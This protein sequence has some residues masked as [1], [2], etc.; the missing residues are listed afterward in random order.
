[1]TKITYPAP[2]VSSLRPV[3]SRQAG[4]GSEYPKN[5]AVRHTPPVP[6][7]RMPLRPRRATPASAPGRPLLSLDQFLQ[8]YNDLPAHTAALGYCDDGLPVLF[9][10]TQAATGPLLI[11]GDHGSGK[12]NLLRLLLTSAIRAST[13]R[14]LK[15][16]L[17]GAH[18]EEYSDLPAQTGDPKHCI[19]LLGSYDQE[20]G[21]AIVRMAELAEERYQSRRAEP[22]VL[23]VIDDVRFVAAATTD[24]RLNFEW[25]LKHGPA[26]QVW[27]VVTLPTE[28][29]L[30]MGRWTAHFRTRIL[31]KMPDK[32]ANRLGLYPGLGA[33]RLEAGKQFGVYMGSNWMR[34][35]V[36]RASPAQP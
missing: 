19:E 30:E 24:T 32:P 31:G 20:A 5:T 11:L 21:K 16:L 34:F 12:T 4:A 28:T 6:A 22:A 26:V 36:P 10:F 25:L 9:D 23:V 13:P 15:Y 3:R 7:P 35:W 29:A 8:R 27:P 17:I 1:M 33:A 18:P 14:Q 2:D